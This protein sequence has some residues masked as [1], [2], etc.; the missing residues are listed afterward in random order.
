MMKQLTAL[1]LIA[2]LTL[3]PVHADDTKTHA[4]TAGGAAAVGAAAGG[5]TSGVV[6]TLGVAGGGGAVA[7]GLAPFVAVG[8]VVGLAGYGIY[9]I[10][11]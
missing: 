9:R 1:L 4:A 11:R 10:F 5:A 2:T 6:G 3:S 7:V 8:A